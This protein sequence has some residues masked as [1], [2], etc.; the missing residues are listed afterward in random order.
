VQGS[1]A[2]LLTQLKKKMNNV[3][4]F[5]KDEE[6]EDEEEDDAK[7]D[8]EKEEL[9]GRGRRTAVLDSKLRTD[10]SSEEKRKQH[11][12]E[13]AQQLNEQAKKRLAQKGEDKEKEKV[14]K[15]T[16]SYKSR[17]Q[18]PIEPEVKELKIY[19]GKYDLVINDRTC[20][21]STVSHY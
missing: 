16:V 14:R 5:L 4:I 20:L 3:G 18:M 7:A 2:T 10:S 17:S 13:L 1:P 6:D 8:K 9:M 19:V 11:Q 12:K 15:S 21:H